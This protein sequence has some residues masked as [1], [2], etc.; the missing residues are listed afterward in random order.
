MFSVLLLI[1]ILVSERL[2]NCF[3]HLPPNINLSM[4]CSFFTQHSLLIYSLNYLHIYL[5]ISLFPYAFFFSHSV[6][7]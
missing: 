3:R 1:V 4:L 6:A 5:L 7:A 2:F